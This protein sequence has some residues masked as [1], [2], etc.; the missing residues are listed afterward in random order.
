MSMLLTSA[1]F[2]ASFHATTVASDPPPTRVDPVT[3]AYHGVEIVDKYRWL[4]PLESAS[5]AVREW[6]DAQNA[7]TRAT[8]DALPGREA[9][10][11]TLTEVMSL[12]SI[13]T[14]RMAGRYYFNTERR[15]DQNHGV[16][17]VRTS[18]DGEPRELLNPNTLDESGLTSLDWYTPSQDGSMLAFGLSR[19]GDENSVL[20][21]LDVESG[22]WRADEIPGKVRGVSWMPDG[23]SFFYQCLED[24]DNPYS[25]RIRHHVVGTHPREDRTL[26]SQYTEGPLATTW[27]PGAWTSAD[28]RWMILIYYTSTRSNDIWAIDLDRWFRTGEFVMNTILEGDDS[29][30][31]GVVVGDTLYMQTTHGASNGRVFAVDLTRPERDAWREV[32]P[33]RPD[34]VLEGLSLARGMLVVQYGRNASTRIERFRLDGESLGELDLPGIGSA[35]VSTDEDRTDAFLSYTSYNDPSSIWRVDLVTGERKLWARPDVPGFDADDYVVKQVRYRSKDGTEVPMFI[36]HRKGLERD[37][38]NPTVLYGYGGFNI[39]LTP[40]F[41]PTRIPWLVGG[42]V[43]AV[44][45]LRGGGEFGD[46]WHAAGTL[47]DKQNV[48]DD[49][50]AAAEFLIDEGYTSPDHLAVL[51]GSNGGLLTGA[52]MVQRPDL[53]AAVISAVPLLDMLRYQDFLMARYW[54]PEYGDSANPEHFEWLREYSPYHNI[55]NG[56]DYPAAI[57]TAGEN[58]TRVHPLHAR[59]MAAALQAAATNDMSEDP[60][61]LWVDRDGGHGQGKPL[62]NRVRES[63][64]LWSFLM[65][66]TGMPPRTGGE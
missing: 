16:L 55:I 8:L 57:F 42:G 31:S 26:F 3:D 53:F 21:L 22:E 44:A 50:I 14:P 63:A 46:A 4:E 37:G 62:K 45:N 32:I 64:D 39:S 54:V 10:E 9:L 48:F 29:T 59:K 58:D 1:L 6:T 18:P 13:G 12:P 52:V 49:F 40:S 20:H 17:Y 19:A 2:A 24:L 33:E 5:D 66:Q 27:G 28:G 7:Y 51:G 65:W 41:N 38:S 60:I 36:V 35:R 43:Y 11:A 23:R 34:A 56:R 25:A 61:L 30:S 47:G 15:G